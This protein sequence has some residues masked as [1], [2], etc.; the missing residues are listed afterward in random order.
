MTELYKCSDCDQ[1]TEPEPQADDDFN[2]PTCGRCGWHYQCDYC[3]KPLNFLFDCT[4]Q[5]CC[6]A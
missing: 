2:P 3:G 6:E 5:E 1:L 4:T